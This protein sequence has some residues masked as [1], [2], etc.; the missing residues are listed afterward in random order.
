MI[1]YVINNT[2]QFYKDGN[3]LEGKDCTAEIYG[4]SIFIMFER[5]Y[6]QSDYHL[7][8]PLCPYMFQGLI[9]TF[10]GYTIVSDFMKFIDPADADSV[11]V[12]IT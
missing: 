8:R 3:I 7:P 9:I 6:F 5:I 11:D 10:I 4:E 1:Y 2:F 12:T